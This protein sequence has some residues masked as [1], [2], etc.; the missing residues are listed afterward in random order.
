MFWGHFL[1]DTD[2]ST[3]VVKALR[4]D[5]LGLRRKSPKVVMMVA[6]PAMNFIKNDCKAVNVSFLT[7]A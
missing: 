2:K 1:E 5:G 6:G 4:V 3:D 7:S